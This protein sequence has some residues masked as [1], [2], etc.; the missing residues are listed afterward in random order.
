MQFRGNPTS[1]TRVRPATQPGSANCESN[2]WRAVTSDNATGYYSLV[3]GGPAEDHIA[4]S[5]AAPETGNLI[6]CTYEAAFGGGDSCRCATGTTAPYGYYSFG[7]GGTTV[8]K[9]WIRFRDEVSGDRG[10]PVSVTGMLL[11]FVCS[12]HYFDNAYDECGTYEFCD[13]NSGLVITPACEIYPPSTL[14]T[15]LVITFLTS[16]PGPQVLGELPSFSGP[17]FSFRNSATTI[18][19]G[20][21]HNARGRLFSLEEDGLFPNPCY[22]VGIETIAMSANDSSRHDGIINMLAFRGDYYVPPA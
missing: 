17:T 19:N 21:G 12:D 15:Q 10:I 1:V 5:V 18:G 13:T 4:Y 11:Q 22:G 7:E 16:D 6:K 2:N 14:E 9:G 20:G 8:A 3:D